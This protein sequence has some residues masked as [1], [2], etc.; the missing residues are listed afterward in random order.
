MTTQK[1]LPLIAAI[2]G[3]LIAYI[4]SRPA[5]DDAGI[6]AGALFLSAALIGLLLRRRPWLC[7]ILIGVWLPA[8]Q[9]YRTHDF[10]MLVIAL[11]PLVGA[12]IGWGFRKVF[13]ETSALS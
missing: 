5:W 13:W 8:V 11:I 3:I 10:R 4:D 9:I 7:G 12:Y 1:I 2:I 6:T